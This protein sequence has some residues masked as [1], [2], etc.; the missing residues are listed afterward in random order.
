ME[1]I[2]LVPLWIRFYM[3]RNHVSVR[4]MCGTLGITDRTWR[5]WLADPQGLSLGDMDIIAS[6]LGV[7]IA[8]LLREV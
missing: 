6:R 2:E 1:I 3:D 5:S 4:D 8:D 7:K